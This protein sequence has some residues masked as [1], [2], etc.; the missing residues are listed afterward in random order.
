M[1]TEIVHNWL[2]QLELALQNRDF[3]K[4]LSLFH[5]E[6]F[7]RDLVSFTWN[8]KTLEGKEEIGAMLHTVLP[9]VKPHSWKLVGDVSDEEGVIGANLTFET[10]ELYGEGYLRLIDGKC[11]TMLTSATALK[12]NSAGKALD[13]HP[14]CLIIGGGQ[15]GIA[16][17][18]RLKRLHVP[19]LIIEKNGR[20]GDSWRN[21]YEALWLHD[22]VWT[23]HLPY[24]P[25]PKDWP[26][27]PHKDQLGDWLEAYTRE[28]DLEYW[29][30]SECLNARYDEERETWSVLIN[31]NGSQITLE[32]K[33]LVLATGMSGFPFTPK[34]PGANN[35]KGHQCHT[36]RFASGKAYAQKK[37]VVLG[38]ST[39]AHDICADLYKHD[40]DVTMIQPSSSSV[41]RID[42]M[43]EGF[44]NYANPRFSTHQADLLRASV[45][46]KVKTAQDI[47]LYKKIKLQ[48]ASFYEQLTNAGFLLDF[49]EDESGVSMKYH[50]RGSGYYID[51]G[52]SR[53]IIDKKIKLKSGCNISLIKEHSVVFTDQSEIPADLI[54]YA[55]G[56]GPMEQWVVQLISHDVAKKI[57]P[58]WGIGSNTKKDP[59]PWEGELRNM[60]KPTK[61][62][63]LWLHGGNLAQS[64]FYSHQLALQIQ[65]RMLGLAT[66]VFGLN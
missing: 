39:S 55:T 40:A 11:W 62:K 32:P 23:H 52:A 37:C 2:C 18:A 24:L 30:S 3:P 33:H 5:E 63:A 35:F 31:L 59:G 17:A 57:G 46:Y 6:C 21:R 64:R 49:G 13:H 1:Q 9:R 20:P 58:C 26:L 22:P 48:D 47:S 66:S 42:T 19:A 36:T 12:E 56:F 27:F 7:W 41:V 45:P 14:Y 54:V 4:I 10:S 44:K 25:F 29:T 38:S 28:M 60:W 15:A 16:L 50:R 65:A 43:M 61:Q 34:F 8:I 53:L 51:V